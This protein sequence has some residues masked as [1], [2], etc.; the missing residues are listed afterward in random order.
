MVPNIPRFMMVSA[1]MHPMAIMY[2][3]V[4]AL[5]AFS[6]RGYIRSAPTHG[7]VLPPI[8]K[9]PTI[10]AWAYKYAIGQPFVCP[11]NDLSYAADFIHM[12]F[13]T[14]RGIH[15]QPDDLPRDGSYPTLHA[16]HEQNASS[17]VRLAGSSGAN[18]F[19]CIA[20]ESQ[21]FGA[22]HMARL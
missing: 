16:D 6:I 12:M 15:R 3:V 10:A 7:R 1:T 21:A 22:P 8:A 2:G 19:A 14:V 17:T 13:A 9:M 4:G 18:P 11:R 5:S 20:A